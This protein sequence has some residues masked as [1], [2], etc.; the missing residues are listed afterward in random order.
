MKNKVTNRK[1]IT[2]NTGVT[3]T[4]EDVSTLATLLK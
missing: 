3:R 4:R 1:H 2:H